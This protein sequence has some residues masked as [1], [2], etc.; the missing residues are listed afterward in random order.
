MDRD[1]GDEDVFGD[2]D[3]SPAPEAGLEFEV[4]KHKVCRRPMLPSKAKVDK[5]YPLHVQYR[6]W[7]SHC[8]AGKARSTQHRVEID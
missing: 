1:K 7:C 2:H 3:V 4:R 5:H 8:A 6:S